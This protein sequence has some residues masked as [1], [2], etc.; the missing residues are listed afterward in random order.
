MTRL[1][2]A[3]SAVLLSVVLGACGGDGDEIASDPGPATPTPTVE[4]TST[5][6]PTVGTYPSFAPE[7]YT[8]TLVLACFCAGGGTPVDVTVRDGEVT[9]ATY[10]G[11][12]RGA[13]AGTPADQL[14]WLTINDVIDEANDTDAASIEVDWPAGQDYPNSVYV[15]EDSDTVDEERGYQ[16]SSVVVG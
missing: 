12:G 14:M 16:I 3:A 13:E 10:D 6:A 1:A 9:D 8:Y 2:L 11:D 4:P 15:D 7:D 5:A